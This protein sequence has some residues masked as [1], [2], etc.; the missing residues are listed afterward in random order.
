M[1]RAHLRLSEYP[2][3]V[4]IVPNIAGQGFKMYAQQVSDLRNRF[5]TVLWLSI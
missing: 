5:S 3:I 4:A 2:A 1:I